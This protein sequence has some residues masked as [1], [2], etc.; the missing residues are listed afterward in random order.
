MIELARKRILRKRNDSGNKLSLE[1]RKELIAKIRI[2][3]WVPIAIV[4]FSSLLLYLSLQEQSGTKL[5]LVDGTIPS[6]IDAGTR[7]TF[8]FEILNF[9]QKG[10]LYTYQIFVDGQ[11]SAIKRVVIGKGERKRF[12]ENAFIDVKGTHELEVKLSKE[13]GQEYF[14]AFKIEVT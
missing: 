8:G 14:A 12:F 1:G 3:K 13:S 4:L 9:E 7:F 5:R 10:E 6:S 11:K 2:G